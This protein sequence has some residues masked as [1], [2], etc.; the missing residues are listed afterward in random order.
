MD[1]SSDSAHT[2]SNQY[3]YEYAFLNIHETATRCH[4]QKNVGGDTR[5]IDTDSKINGLKHCTFAE[6]KYTILQH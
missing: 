3:S 5:Y 6:R 1:L 4:W 2:F